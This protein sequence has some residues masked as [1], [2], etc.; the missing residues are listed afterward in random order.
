MRNSLSLILTAPL[1]QAILSLSKQMLVAVEEASLLTVF[2]PVH[3]R[4]DI[5]LHGKGNSKLPWRK[6][7]QPRHLVDMEDSDQ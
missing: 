6:A 1:K 7:D 2:P 4:V 3:G 5:R